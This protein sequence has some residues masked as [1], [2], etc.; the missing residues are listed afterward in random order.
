MIVKTLGCVLLAMCAALPAFAQDQQPR[1]QQSWPCSGKVDPAFTRTAEAT[2]GKVFLFAPTEISGASDDLLASTG[3][4]ETIF[5][6]SDSLADDIHEFDIPIDSTIE[7]VYFFLSLQCLRE[8]ALVQPSGEPLPIDAPGVSYHPFQAIRL[9]T[10]AAPQPGIWKVRLAGRGWSSVIVKG[11]TTLSLGNVSLR[12]DGELLRGQVPLGQRVR[13]TA[14]VRD[15]SSAVGFQFI[16]MAGALLQTFELA[17]EPDG[18]GG[19]TYAG[20]VSLPQS[21]FRVLIAGV[22]GKGFRVQ[23][24]TPELFTSNR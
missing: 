3:H 12:H 1:Y 5:R 15:E 6:A 17:R 19:S 11:K 20:D 8:I 22:D 10:I 2:G 16:S 14:D 4:E 24:V 18:T 23:R 9:F 7:S 13:I 21:E